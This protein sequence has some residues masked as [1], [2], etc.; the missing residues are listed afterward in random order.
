VPEAARQG[1]QASTTRLALAAW[2]PLVTNMPGDRLT[3]REALALVL[4]RLRWQ[5]ETPVYIVGQPW[6]RGRVA[7]YETLAHPG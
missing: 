6:A 4:G 7:E 2:T 1:R 5:I 3:L